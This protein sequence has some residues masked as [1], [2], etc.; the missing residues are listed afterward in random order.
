MYELPVC[1]DGVHLA[2]SPQD[3][4]ADRLLDFLTNPG[5][6]GKKSITAKVG[7]KRAR[8]AKAKAKTAKSAAPA[9]P[10]KKALIP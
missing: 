5:D 3:A 4:S 1:E 7:E 8:N 10:A 9:A 2:C 6:S